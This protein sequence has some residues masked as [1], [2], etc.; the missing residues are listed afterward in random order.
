MPD[1][2]R[3]KLAAFFAPGTVAHATAAPR[4]I[5]IP[6]A[7]PTRMVAAGLLT[8]LI[9]LAALWPTVDNPRPLILWWLLVT[10]SQLGL[11][12]I[13]R[14]VPRPAGSNAL[15]EDLGHYLLSFGAVFAGAAWGALPLLGPYT[16]GMPAQLTLFLLLGGITLG[17]A[18]VLSASRSAFAV[19]VL[20]TLLPLFI[21]TVAA[22]EA[23]IALALIQMLFQRGGN[24]DRIAAGQQFPGQRKIGLARLH[25]LGE[26]FE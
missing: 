15:D 25:R 11:A 20:A 16:A 7:Y 3:V 21:L 4:A 18:A 2:L 1:A 13:V 12:G 19:F 22:C 17:G 23:A 6:D 9:A 26:D 5:H 10:V 8:C 14:R 24:L